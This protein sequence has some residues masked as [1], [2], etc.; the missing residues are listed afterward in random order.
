MN[1][2]AKEEMNPI[3]IQLKRNIRQRS[4]F[5]PIMLRLP[6]IVLLTALSTK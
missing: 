1:S 2:N 5:L 4:L 3:K 6:S